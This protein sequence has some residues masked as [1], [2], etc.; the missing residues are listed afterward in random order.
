MQCS[1]Q[2]V[3]GREGTL[4]IV[5]DNL[6]VITIVTVPPPFAHCHL[7]R[8]DFVH[9]IDEAQEQDTLVKC[10]R[11]QPPSAWVIDS[12]IDTNVT[13]WDQRCLETM[14]K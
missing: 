5:G 14:Y 12:Q 2:W 7:H 6:I 3:V 4:I 1:L 11:I 10:L 13:I 9:F 8:Q